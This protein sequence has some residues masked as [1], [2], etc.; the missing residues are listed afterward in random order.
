MAERS[1]KGPDGRIL[2]HH[3]IKE[4]RIYRKLSLRKLADRL[5]REPGIPLMTFAN[6]GRIENGQQPYTEEV[7]EA[8]AGALAC[9][10]SDLISVNPQKDGEIVDLLRL[11]PDRNR[12]QAIRILQALAEVA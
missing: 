4:W 2:G 10:V 1:H 12:D 3:F 7:L 8:L 6:L 11:I 9:S 5:E